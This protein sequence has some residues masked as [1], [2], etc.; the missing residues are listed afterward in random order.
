V[1]LFDE[2]R[3]PMP[4]LLAGTMLFEFH[5]PDGT[6]M[7]KWS[8]TEEMV[9]AASQHLPP[10]PGYVFTLSLIAANVPD[11]VET[12]AVDLSVTFTP[13]RGKPVTSLGGTT[14]RLG[15]IGGN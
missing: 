4:L 13:K 10:G 2:Q 1:Y 12:Q 8:M 5:R 6:T 11:K 15:R 14:L 7:A 3:H 9:A